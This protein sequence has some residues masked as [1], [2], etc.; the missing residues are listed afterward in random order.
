MASVHGVSRRVRRATRKT[1]SNSWLEVLE[2]AGYVVRGVLYAV[3]GILALGLAL[4][5]GG[6]ATDQSGSLVILSGGP[7]G[8][9]VLFAVVIGLG[10]Y[11]I[12]GFVR[13]IFDPLHRGHDAVGVAERLGFVWSAVAYS[14]IVL[15]ALNMLAGSDGSAHHDGTQMAIA[16]VLSMPAGQLF[17][18]GIG[19]VAT[20]VGLGQFVDA[21]RAIFKKDMQRMKMR[22]AEK[23]IVDSLGRLGMVS[24]GITFTLVGWLVLQGAWHDDP[25]LVRGFAGAFLLLLNAPAGRVLLGIV[26]AGFIAL[27][28]HSFAC[29]RWIRLLSSAR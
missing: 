24:R 20:G 16:R 19:I 27:G 14:S 8:K 17:A 5:V 18:I 13:A 6:I 29:A 25:S 15:L 7:A 23:T 26:A 9:A 22:K 21:Y 2:R 12:W 4:G 10:A 1:A 28:V 11:A 3:M